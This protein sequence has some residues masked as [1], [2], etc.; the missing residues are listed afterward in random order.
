MSQFLEPNLLTSL[1]KKPET[2]RLPETKI[3]E[4]KAKYLPVLEQNLS[5]SLARL[6]LHV[7]IDLIKRR[8]F[9]K[10]WPNLSPKLRLRVGMFSVEK[11]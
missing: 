6:E 3:R 5:E 11:P 9:S 10:P 2:L 7:H 1:C 4:I 8:L